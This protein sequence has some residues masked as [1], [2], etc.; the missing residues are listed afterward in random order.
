MTHGQPLRP[1]MVVCARQSDLTEVAQALNEDCKWVSH[2][3]QL[4]GVPKCRV[5]A[6][7]PLSDE[8]EAALM[9]WA[10]YTKSEVER[11]G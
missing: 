5:I 6:I 11:R 1:T 2:A 9:S 8:L 7:G 3:Y 10:R 4:R